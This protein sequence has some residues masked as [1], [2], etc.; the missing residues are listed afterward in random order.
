MTEELWFVWRGCGKLYEVSD[1]GRVRN[2]STGHILKPDTTRKGYHRYRFY[3]GGKPIR[4][5]AHRLVWEVFVEKTP[6]EINH[7]DGVKTNNALWNLEA[8]TRRGNAVH[9]AAMGLLAT[10]MRNGSHTKPHRR[11]V[12]DRHGSKTQ[13]EKWAHRN[14]VRG[15][16]VGGSKLTADKVREIRRR[17]ANGERQADLA[18]EF[19]V[20]SATM[21]NIVRRKLWKHIE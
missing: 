19:G 1:L 6:L 20:G 7:K 3:E 17:F 9:A 2:R 18:R 13:P 11:A 8:V 15:E 12:G 5:Q 14:V 4:V 16:G 21:F 10:G